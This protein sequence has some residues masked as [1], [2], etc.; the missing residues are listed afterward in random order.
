MV[1]AI[2]SYLFTGVLFTRLAIGKWRGTAE[3]PERTLEDV[4][5]RLEGEEK[6]LFLN[7]MGKML[8]W[9]REERSSAKEL[10]DD[11]WLNKV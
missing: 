4:E 9:K 2:E 6:T 11:L 7:F 10:L 3:I 8:K 1:C 5:K